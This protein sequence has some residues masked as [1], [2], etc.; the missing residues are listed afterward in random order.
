MEAVPY[1]RSRRSAG[2]NGSTTTI[3]GEGFGSSLAPVP[4][5]SGYFYGLTDRGPNA[6][7]PDGNKSEPLTSF[8]PE[9]GEFQLVDGQARLL[10]TI[11]LRG[12]RAWEA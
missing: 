3:S 11:P 8:T 10:K 7:A 9:I 6:D 4:H 2:P 1:R 5:K 12:R